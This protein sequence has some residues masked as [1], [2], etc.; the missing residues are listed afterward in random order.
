MGAKDYHDLLK[1]EVINTVSGLSLISRIVVEGYISGLHRS[2]SVGPGMEF[3]QYRG[4]EP[5]DDLR[6]LDWKMLARSGRYYIKQSEM[7]SHV[8]VKFIVDASASMEHEENGIS[9]LEFARVMVA[10]LSHMAQK[11]GDSVGLFALNEDDFVSI[12][13]KA[14]QKHFNRLLLELLK[15]STKG[16]WPELSIASRRI[17]NRGEKEL[18]FFLTD[19]YEDVSE[20]S[21]FV[22]NLKTANNE[23]V[24]TQIMT[25]SEM[26]FDYKK[27][28]T[29]EDL[30]TGTKIKVDVNKAKTAYLKAL[31]KKV[32][33]TKEQLLSQGIHYHLFRMDDNLGNALQLFLKERIRLL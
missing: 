25:G 9:K 33:Q 20:L 13:P 26:D 15:I 27:S 3:S 19:M 29:F 7:E 11:Q 24:V 23:V 6:L 14:D 8:T 30:E 16:K 17:H 31:D 2:K 10:C 28:V 22:K 32:S 5:G 21:D 1:P 4:Y 12:Y 18:V